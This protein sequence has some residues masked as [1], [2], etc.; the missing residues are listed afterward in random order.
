MNATQHITETGQQKPSYSKSEEI[1]SSITHGLGAA[2]SIAGLIYL[3]VHASGS[4]EIWHWVSF[5]VYGLS[6]FFLYLNSTLYHSITH[7]KVKHVLRVLDHA[8]IY[9]LIAGTYTP[10]LLIS[11]RNTLGWS[12]FV[13]VWVIAL[14]GMAFTPLFL[15]RFKKLSLF[16][17]IFMGW[18]SVVLIYELFQVLPLQGLLWLISGGVVYTA[19]T[20]FYMWKS[21]KFSHPIW[22]M[23]VLGGSACHFISVSQLVA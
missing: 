17:Y 1:A 10:F 22:H 19:G 18:L 7:P 6:M 11:L 12:M 21:M 16:S 23:F 13:T 15:K 20:V 8:S 14:V 3:L 5:L 9:L 4:G 2:L